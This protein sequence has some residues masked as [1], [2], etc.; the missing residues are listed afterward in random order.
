MRND[1]LGIAVL[2]LTAAVIAVALILVIV[3]IRIRRSLVARSSATLQEALLEAWSQRSPEHIR[4]TMNTVT[5]RAPHSLADLA[6]C[7][8]IAGD[9][10]L[11][12]PELV[13][14]VQASVHSSGLYA[15]LL[16]MLESRHSQRR[17]LAILL[18]GLPIC[19]MS[20]HTFARFL[21]DPDSTVRLTAVASLAQARTPQAAAALITALDEHELEDARI[22]ER[23][24]QQW[25]VPVVISALSDGR[26]ESLTRRGLLSALALSKDP[27]ALPTGIRFAKSPD[28][29]EKIRALRVL[30]ALAD[31]ATAEQLLQIGSIARDSANSPNAAVRNIAATLLGYCDSTERVEVLTLLARDSDWF[32]RRSAVRSL[33]EVGPTGVSRV[34]ELTQDAD[35]FAAQR[36]R[37]EWQRRAMRLNAGT[38]GDG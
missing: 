15:H 7:V 1:T 5:S 23:L 30:V 34:S 24:G 17:G 32:V 38:V 25:A 20:E 11:W 27:R 22:I 13:D 10:R 35:T 26:Y 18:G 12:D 21:D 31:Q 8:R 6:R 36:A 19:R 28:D 29:E 37:E 2:L 33:L 3:G 16:E 9:R 4:T 14:V